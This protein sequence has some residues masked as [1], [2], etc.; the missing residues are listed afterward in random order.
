[1]DTT[2]TNLINDNTITI[3]TTVIF[4]GS[5]VALILQHV[6]KL[7]WYEQYILPATPLVAIVLGIGFA[8][9]TNQPNPN[10]TGMVIGGMAVTGYNAFKG[11]KPDPEKSEIK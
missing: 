3:N 11:K 4:L 8:W 7:K 9:L 6:K 5:M 2:I 1:M 10:L